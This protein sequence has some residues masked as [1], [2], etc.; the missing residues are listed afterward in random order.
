MLIQDSQ[1]G[2]FHEVP[3]HNVA[4]YGGYGQVVY[5]GLGNPVGIGWNP[6][7]LVSKVVNAVR[8]VASNIP[9]VGGLVNRLI[10]GTPAP[11]QSPYPYLQT[12]PYPAPQVPPT[13]PGMDMANSMSPEGFPSPT[14]QTSPWPYGWTNPYGQG[15]GWRGRRY[16]RGYGRYR[17]WSRGWGRSYGYG[18]RLWPGYRGS[19]YYRR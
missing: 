13:M 4:G 2:Y 9:V 16:W 11:L 15:G 8:G 1:T 19:M 10:P 18:Q 12:Q 17:P 6:F 3:D 5:D 7:S 14:T